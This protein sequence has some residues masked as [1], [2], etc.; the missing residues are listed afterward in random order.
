MLEIEIRAYLRA[1]TR[2]G[3]STAGGDAAD[4][5]RWPSATLASA[6]TALCGGVPAIVANEDLLLTSANTGMVHSYT[7]FVWIDHPLC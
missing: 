3:E 2:S 7:A 1:T 5:D 4:R 6:R